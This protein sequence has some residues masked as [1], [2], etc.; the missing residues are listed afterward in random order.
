M[1]RLSTAMSSTT[2]THPSRPSIPNSRQIRVSLTS[3]PPEKYVEE[4]LRNSSQRT[5]HP[6]STLGDSTT[7]SITPSM[8]EQDSCNGSIKWVFRLGTA[9]FSTF[10]IL[11]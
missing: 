3:R 11:A 7:L 6:S 5:R 9:N 2:N 4:D 10:C 8:L 1:R